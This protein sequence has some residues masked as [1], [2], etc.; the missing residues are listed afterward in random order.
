MTN[1]YPVPAGRNADQ[2]CPGLRGTCTRRFDSD[3]HRDEKAVRRQ[4][5]HAKNGFRRITNHRMRARGRGS[6]DG[7]LQ[8]CAVTPDGFGCA[9]AHRDLFDAVGKNCCLSC[10]KPS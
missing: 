9:E 1:A 8:R 2:R 4:R 7:L 5:G 10:V 3:R 6:E